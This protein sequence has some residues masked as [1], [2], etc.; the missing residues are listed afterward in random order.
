MNALLNK[1]FAMIFWTRYVNSTLF[2]SYY[3]FLLQKLLSC[4]IFLLSYFGGAKLFLISFSVALF[5]ELL[6]TLGQIKIG[7]IET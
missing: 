1:V 7:W 2:L 3:F 5:F 6:I 4:S